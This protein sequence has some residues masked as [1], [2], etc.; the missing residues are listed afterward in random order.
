MT[1]VGYLIESTN[2][3]TV[4]NLKTT[5]NPSQ[6]KG[7]SCN[8]DSGGP[9]F[10]EGTNII[11]SVVSFGMNPQCKGQDYSLPARPRPGPVMDHR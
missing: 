3:V 9:V 6:N 8:G 7:G 5:A 1:A 11:A 4:F 2:P 10:F